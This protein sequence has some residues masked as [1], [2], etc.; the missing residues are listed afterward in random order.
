MT[1][2]LLLRQALA[3]GLILEFHD[4]SKLMTADRWQVVLE[5]RLPIP[6]SAATLPPDLADRAPEV[7]AALGPEILF[8]QQEVHHFIDDQ[9]FPGL[10]QEIQTRL[11]KGLEGYLGHPDFAGR[12]LRKKFAEHQAK[13][14]RKQ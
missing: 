2:K 9:E 7:I 14:T 6:V 12:Y 8:I 1:G 13:V 3:N 11:F 5:V 10:L 4:R